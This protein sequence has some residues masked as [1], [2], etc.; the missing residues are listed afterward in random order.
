MTP[1]AF[2]SWLASQEKAITSPNASVSGAAVF[3]NNGCGACHTLT[4]AAAT[5]KVGPD[6]DKLPQWAAQAK[7][8]L[9]SFVKTSITDPNAYIQPGFPKNVM[10][11]TFGSTLSAQQLDALVQYLISSSKKG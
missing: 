2:N 6:L 9:A 7:Q 3:K 11:P 8:P 10:P 4:A 5:G 1:A